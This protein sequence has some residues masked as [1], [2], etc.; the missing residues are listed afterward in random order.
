MWINI[1]FKLNAVSVF[2]FLSVRY[3]TNN[4]SYRRRQT[5][6]FTDWT[7]CVSSPPLADFY[8]SLLQTNKTVPLG[9]CY[10]APALR[11]HALNMSI[12]S[13]VSVQY[14]ALFKKKTLG[15]QFPKSAMSIRSKTNWAS[16]FSQLP[17]T[18][19][20]RRIGNYKQLV[21]ALV[22]ACRAAMPPGVVTTPRS[23]SVG[24]FC[25]LLRPHFTENSV[26]SQGEIYQ[27][28]VDWIRYAGLRAPRLSVWTYWT[29]NCSN[30]S[31]LILI[32][33]VMA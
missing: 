24:C 6:V 28:W 15:G 3:G 13:A 5:T 12:N 10:E 26:I 11:Q 31:R 16:A 21:R 32:L 4:P 8:R 1:C 18:P 25:A 19:R 30:D 2:N 17:S 14:R 20:Q 27:L 9:R 7:T 33:F 23:S 29:T 22:P